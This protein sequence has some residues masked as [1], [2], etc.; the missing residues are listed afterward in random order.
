MILLGAILFIRYAAVMMRI[1]DKNMLS[2]VSSIAAIGSQGMIPLASLLV[3]C[4]L[5]FRSRRLY[6]LETGISGS[7]ENKHLFYSLSKKPSTARLNSS[8]F[9]FAIK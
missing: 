9:L 1:A 8:G 6:C 2:K 7:S 4:S 5:G 3:F